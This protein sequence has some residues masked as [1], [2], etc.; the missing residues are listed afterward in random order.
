M[1]NL[2]APPWVCMYEYQY[3]TYLLWVELWL[4][5]LVVGP[6]TTMGIPP[7]RA[8]FGLCTDVSHPP[9]TELFVDINIHCNSVLG[10]NRGKRWICDKAL[11]IFNL[12]SLDPLFLIISPP[13]QFRPSH[14]GWDYRS[15][16]PFRLFSQAQD[17]CTFPL[18][19]GSFIQSGLCMPTPE[20]LLMAALEHEE[21]PIS[22]Y[23]SRSSL[24]RCHPGSLFHEV[25]ARS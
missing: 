9:R 3:F 10:H 24:Y 22:L 18:L 8:F 14:W 15:P 16:L 4:Q 25:H 11:S 7:G 23:L 12:E 6:L 20:P 17:L 5:L 19:V 2:G 21:G 1:F 13:L